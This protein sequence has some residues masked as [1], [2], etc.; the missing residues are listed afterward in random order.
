MY[1]SMIGNLEVRTGLLYW[2]HRSPV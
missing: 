1:I 2:P